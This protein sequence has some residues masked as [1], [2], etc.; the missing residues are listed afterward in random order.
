MQTIVKKDDLSEIK[1]K[2]GL[3]IIDECH[4]IPA[5]TFRE[6]IVNFNSKYIYGFT[7]TPKRKNNDEKLIYCYI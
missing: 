3:I 4:H 6:G 1:N 2:F 7:A 5:K